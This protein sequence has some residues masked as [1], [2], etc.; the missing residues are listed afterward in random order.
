M[1]LVSAAK[2]GLSPDDSGGGLGEAEDASGGLGDGEDAGI[3]VT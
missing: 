1:A 2:H 3:A